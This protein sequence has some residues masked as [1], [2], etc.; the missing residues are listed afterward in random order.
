MSNILDST[1]AI[2][3]S[4]EVANMKIVDHRIVCRFEDKAK[5]EQSSTVCLLFLLLS[6]GYLD[7]SY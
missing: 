5:I 6:E 1:A 4:N 7:L 3:H 2:L